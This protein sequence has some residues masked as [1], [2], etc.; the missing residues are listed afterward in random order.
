MN[1]VSAFQALASDARSIQSVKE[2]SV[3]KFETPAVSDFFTVVPNIKG[4][5]Q[6]AGMKSLEYIT[7]LEDGCGG[8]SQALSF[9][10]IS[11]SWNPRRAKIKIKMCYTEFEGKFTQW[12][13]A[14]GY[15][16]HNLQE[17][18]FFDFITYLVE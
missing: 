1:I 2:I 11:Q 7:T 15:D 8:T 5:Q 13:L 4:G 10:A 16:V 6:V 17:A 14:N 18:E 12:A 3:K 9:P